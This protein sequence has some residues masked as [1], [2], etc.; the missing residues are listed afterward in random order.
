MKK[1]PLVLLLLC[2]SCAP[3]IVGVCAAIGASGF[4]A[5]V[6]YERAQ[7]PTDGGAD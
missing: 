7:Q 6:Y 5:G 2:V 1:L 3:A 4:T